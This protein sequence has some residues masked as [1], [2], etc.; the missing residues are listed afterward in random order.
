MVNIGNAVR[1]IYLTAGSSLPPAI[2]RDRNAIYFVEDDKQLWVGDKLIADHIDPPDIEAYLEPYKVKTVDVIG[3]GTFIAGASLD[4]ATGKLTLTKGTPPSISRGVDPSPEQVVLTP[5]SKFKVVT[6]T[7]LSDNTLYNDS[8]EFTLPNQIDNILITRDGSTSKL[9][10]TISSTDGT[11]TS[12]DLTMFGS[13]AFTEASDYATA[14]QGLKADQAMPAI[15][16]TATGAHITLAADPLEDYQAASKHYVDNAVKAL[17]GAMHFLGVSSTPITDHG[18]EHP[19]I[20]GV[21]IDTW[22]LHPGDVVLYSPTSDTNYLEFVWAFLVNTGYWVQLGDETSYVLKSTQVI[23]GEGLS[24]GGSLTNDVTLSHGETGT[25]QIE[26]YVGTVS[27]EF[28]KAIY[29]DKFGHVTNVD[30]QDITEPVSQIATQVIA[31]DPTIA[32][33]A[34]IQELVEEAIMA[35]TEIVHRSEIAALVDEAIMADPEIVHRS[36]IDA[37]VQQAVADD[38]DIARKSEIDD[39]VEAAI[40][41][42]TTIVHQADLPDAVRAIIAEDDTIAHMSDLPAW[43]FQQP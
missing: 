28:V 42:D 8:K 13:A 36:E 9:I 39:L 5:G 12:T 19:K 4:E 1:F 14:A 17:T 22:E 25:G 27:T 33:K 10:L 18:R 29:A 34:E 20:N 24:G 26:T 2:D 21:E 32:R 43:I 35:D 7:P 16:G 40:A 41:R 37:L 15:N 3:D 38:P 11:S 31:T 6:D 30:V 23:A